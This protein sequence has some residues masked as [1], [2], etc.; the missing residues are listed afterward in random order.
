MS[1]RERRGFSRRRGSRG[2]R[3]ASVGP[4]GADPS[5]CRRSIVRGTDRGAV[6]Q[7]GHQYSVRACSPI[8]RHS[9]VSPQRWHRWPLRPYTASPPLH[10]GSGD[11]P[12]GRE[13]RPQ[14]RRRRVDQADRVVFGERADAGERAELGRPQHLGAIDVADTAHHPLV[15]QDL[16]EPGLRVGDTTARRLTTSPRSVSALQRSGPSRPMPG[17]PATVGLTVRLDERGVETD[18]HPALDLDRRPHLVVRAT[19]AVAGVDTGATNPVI[20]MWV[21]STRPSSHTISRCLPWLSTRSMIRPACGPGP[22]RRGASKRT[23][24][25]PTNAVRSALAVRWM[26]SPSG[27]DH[28]GTRCTSIGRGNRAPAA[29]SA[30]DVVDRRDPPSRDPE[31]DG[32]A[33]RSIRDVMPLYLPTIPFA[34]VLGVAITESAMPTAIGYSSNLD[35]RRRVAARH[36]HPRR[37]RHLADAR[38]HRVGD[39]PASRDVQRGDVGPLPRPADVVPLGRLVR[40]DRPDVRAHRPPHRP[41]DR[42]VWR[43]YYMG[44]GMFL[45]VAW[46]IGVT[47]GMVVGS[48]IPTEWRLDV[49]AGGDVRRTRRDGHLDA[50]GGRRGDHRCGRVLRLP[51]HSRTTAASCSAPSPASPPASSPTRP[52]TDGRDRLPAMTPG[53]RVSTG[54]A[55]AAI[56]VDLD[57]HLRRRVPG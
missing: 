11:A 37:H 21:C 25:L 55:F 15:E 41:A 8:W 22:I 18:G 38:D 40:A 5:A 47:V 54:A 6:W 28:Q 20:R 12:S 45:L 10:A 24:G 26:V 16:G 29:Y 27:I 30:H 49:D 13:V 56:V 7:P 36:R 2:D 48:A 9:I 51:R 35:V 3:R 42:N 23:I 39:Q 19:P 43:R 46:I 31:L 53:R 34:L 14:H 32:V 50:S 52:A 44:A 33:M 57:H 1:A 4:P 17:M